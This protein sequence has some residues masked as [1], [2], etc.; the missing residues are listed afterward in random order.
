M[1]TAFENTTVLNI[2]KYIVERNIYLSQTMI[3]SSRPSN[4]KKL[5]SFVMQCAFSFEEWPDCNFATKWM[6]IVQKRSHCKR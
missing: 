1:H 5:L 4:E 6:S 2:P 3:P